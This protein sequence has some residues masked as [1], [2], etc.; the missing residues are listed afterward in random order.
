LDGTAESQEKLLAWLY[1]LIRIAKEIKAGNEQKNVLSEEKIMNIRRAFKAEGKDDLLGAMFAAM[2]SL[3][4][5]EEEDE[6]EYLDSTIE[7]ILMQM[8]KGPSIGTFEEISG[9]KET[10]KASWYI[11]YVKDC[12][13]K[14]W[15]TM[16]D[17][18]KDSTNSE[19][20]LSGCL[21]GTFAVLLVKYLYKLYGT[22]GMFSAQSHMFKDDKYTIGNLHT[23]VQSLLSKHSF[24]LELKH[25]TQRLSGFCIATGE[26]LIMP[27]HFG[28][29]EN[30]TASLYT[31][32][33]VTTILDNKS[34]KLVYK[35][36][37]FD[38]CV[39][40]IM[41]FA[42]TPFKNIFKESMTRNR[43]KTTQMILNPYGV[44]PL[45][46][47]SMD[48]HGLD[49][50]YYQE[51]KGHDT[52][53][54]KFYKNRDI[55]YNI[56]GDGMC[57]T[58]VIDN[59]G[60]ILGMHVAGDKTR[61]LGV[62]I[63]WSDQVQTD[64]ANIINNSYTT[65]SELRDGKQIEGASIMTVEGTCRV[66]SPKST[67]YIPSKLYGIYPDST[68]EPVDVAKYGPGTAH[69]L[70]K[71]IMTPSEY[72]TPEE[73]EFAM[74]VIKDFFPTNM[75]LLEEVE[76]VKGNKEKKIAPINM[77]SVNGF[78]NLREKEKYINIEKGEFTDKLRADL[79]NLRSE[80]YNK[81]YPQDWFTYT[82]AIK[83]ELK[84]AGKDPRAF[85]VGTVQH[86]VLCK[87]YFGNTVSH[88]MEN[89]GFNQVQVG[90]NPFEEWGRL[91][92]GIKDKRAKWAGDISKWDGKM[93][94]QVS[95]AVID[96]FVNSLKEEHR[97]IARILLTPLLHTHLGVLDRLYLTT[98]S[99]P[100]GCYLTAVMNSIVNRF[101][102][103]IWYYRQITKKGL[104]PT[105][106]EFHKII[107]YVYGDDKVNAVDFHTDVL[108]ALTMME[109]F[110]SLGMDM[111]TA[112]KKSV[113]TPTQQMSE[114]TFL[115]RG[116]K[117]HNELNK[118]V[119]PLDLNTLQS[120]LQ[121]V[122]KDKNGDDVVRDKV[123]N[124]QREIYLHPNRDELLEDFKN[125]LQGYEQFPILSR[126][127]LKYLYTFETDS[128][129]HLAGMSL[130][131]L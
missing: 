39:F 104:K 73:M 107:D 7:P 55:F 40:K 101:Y 42:A 122:D 74:N 5:S 124:Y 65:R 22:P 80:I 96:L 121:Y 68:R 130:Y 32:N 113:T 76:V 109:F 93:S 53:R 37:E 48:H 11:A 3:E 131:Y 31:K 79:D 78:K 4:D 15:M 115:K 13:A 62:S 14:F 87:Q 102:T 47:V 127:Y 58:V 92:N 19:K 28:I 94:P 56:R 16:K 70:S 129:P 20:W 118:I 75:E 36:C 125:K 91:Y 89:K 106:E 98:H 69:E 112:D 9:E 117:Y 25:G 8:D 59:N 50:A 72:I 38:V 116:F 60:N 82:L 77:K 110:K 46:S 30:M 123:A 33:K 67:C 83:Q 54:N 6:T 41:N 57:G 81:V 49:G 114:I 119:C 64:I 10:V 97:E 108:N 85:C 34:I 99:M 63:I 35:N 126:E 86:Q 128:L 23:K 18:I 61:N 90:I 52:F 26:Y 21:V 12:M 1:A 120:S 111:T 44:V 95:E 84:E 17:I 88:I 105:K 29:T 66:S 51:T 24:E 103:A 45:Y 71:K 2:T 100:S 27:A 43:D